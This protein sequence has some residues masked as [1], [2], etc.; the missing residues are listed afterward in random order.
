M[1]RRSYQSPRREEAARATRRAILDAAED[2]FAV[3]GYAGT[4][5]ADIATGALV[6]PATVKGAFGTKG[7]VLAA[8]IRARLTD[9]DGLALSQTSAWRSALDH[10]DPQQLL[11]ACVA[12]SAELHAR[13]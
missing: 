2:L 8:L 1:S 6:S 11:R 7:G 9:D 4:T 3:R 12:L 5:L 10:T 13:T